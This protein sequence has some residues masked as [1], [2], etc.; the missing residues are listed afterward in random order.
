M[1]AENTIA[2]PGK[3][4]TARSSIITI[5]TATETGTIGTSTNT[6]MTMIMTT[7][8]T[9]KQRVYRMCAVKTAYMQLHPNR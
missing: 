3:V 9:T 7:T 4:S 8:T 6:I 5:G 2:A 1:R